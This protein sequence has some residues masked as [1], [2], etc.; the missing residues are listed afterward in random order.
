[1]TAFR[2]RPWP[3]PWPLIEVRTAP[4]EGFRVPPAAAS[5][6]TSTDFFHAAP[7]RRRSLAGQELLTR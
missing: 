6:G 5:K 7:C 1:L 2:R 3:S 4:W